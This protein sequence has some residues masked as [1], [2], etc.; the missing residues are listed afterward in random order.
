MLWLILSKT[1]ISYRKSYVLFQLSY[2]SMFYVKPF[3]RSELLADL[4]IF[5][6]KS[7]FLSRIRID[8]IDFRILR[9]IL[10]KKWLMPQFLPK[11]RTELQL[12]PDYLLLW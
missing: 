5:C 12:D 8:N 3:S 6:K 1:W 4:A 10:H 9:E 7:L 11:K 2:I